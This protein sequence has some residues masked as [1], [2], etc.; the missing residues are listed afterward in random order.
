MKC[1]H[2]GSEWTVNPTISN[3][4]KSCPFC[5]ETFSLENESLCTAESVLATIYKQY[6]TEVLTDEKKLLSYFSDLA[7]H[8]LKEKRILSY[9]AECNGPQRVF[10][11]INSPEGEQ[12]VCISRIVKEMKENLLVDESASELICNSFFA[13]VTGNQL[14]RIEIDSSDNDVPLDT[15]ISIKKVCPSGERPPLITDDVTHPIGVDNK[16]CPQ[17]SVSISPPVVAT[18]PFSSVDPACSSLTLANKNEKVTEKEKNSGLGMAG[19]FVGIASIVYMIA[20]RICAT[21]ISFANF[22]ESFIGQFEI[23][24]LIAGIVGLAFSIIGLTLRNKKKLLPAFGFAFSF[25][26]VAVFIFIF[27]FN[28]SHVI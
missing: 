2:C 1:N 26:G 7:P 13:A 28:L 23:M 6:G 21:A 11:A 24:S 22:D 4:I 15:K 10:A 16:V 19:F 17:Y 25:I 8:L 5:G 14:A 9:F 27:V 18:V 20:A 3:S 12:A